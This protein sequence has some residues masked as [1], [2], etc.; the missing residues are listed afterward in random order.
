MTDLFRA[1]LG[2]SI[3][4][5]PIIGVLLLNTVVN[6]KRKERTNQ[7]L[8]PIITLVYVYLIY[9][10]THTIGGFINTISKQLFN[11]EIKGLFIFTAVNVASVVAYYIWKRA[12]L[13]FFK[14]IFSKNSPIH[15]YIA[16][17]FYEYNPE[18]STWYLK[19][20][21]IQ[22]RSFLK[23]SYIAVFIVSMIAAMAICYARQNEKVA[24]LFYPVIP[25]LIFGDIYAFFNGIS[26]DEDDIIVVAEKSKTSHR[27][28]YSLL[29]PVLG[30]LFKDK[31]IAEGTTINNEE[32]S[33]DANDVSIQRILNDDEVKIEAYGA[34]M[35]N[36]LKHGILLKQDYLYAGLELLKGK[37]LLFNN[38]FYYD[39][40]PYVFFVMN[41]ILLK[42]KK[43]LIILGRHGIED[44]I[45]EWCKKGISEVTG[46]PYIWNIDILTENKTN[47]DIGILTR[48]EVCN[49]T[50][51][52]KNEDFLSDAEFVFIVEPS[53]LITTAQ[54]GLNSLVR[55]SKDNSKVIFCSTDK[56]CDGLIDSLSHILQTSISE[57]AATNHHIGTSSYMCWSADDEKLQHRMIS[58]IS[59]YL[60]IGTELSFVALK[61][62]VRRTSWYGGERFPV[63]DMHWIAKQYY[64][65][66]LKYADLPITQEYM[67][68]C[69][70]TSSNL[71]NAKVQ[72]INYMT[73]EDEANNLFEARRLFASRALEQGFVNII[74]TNYVL[75]EYMAQNDKIFDADSK[76]I[77]YIVADYDRT[78]RNVLMR[79]LLYMSGKGISE[80]DLKRELKL[81]GIRS[82]NVFESFWDLLCECF[83][84]SVHVSYDGEKE[85]TIGSKK[86]VFTSS[87]FLKK[88]KFSKDNDKLNIVYYLCD[89][90]FNNAILGDLQNVSIIAEDENGTNN[91]LGTEVKGQVFQ[92]YLPGQ[93][94][95]FSGKYYEMIK[96]TNDAQLIVRRAAEHIRG[97]EEY[98][99]IRNYSLSNISYSKEMG[100]VTR[101]LGIK[102]QIGYADITVTTRSYWKMKVYND[103]KTGE[104][105][106]VDNIP[107]REYIK[108]RFLKLDFADV[109]HFES[110]IVKMLTILLNE[111]FRTIF[112]DN[113][114]YI[115][116]VSQAFSEIPDLYTIDAENEMLGSAI[117]FI[118]DSQLDIGLLT[119]LRRNIDRIF[120]IIC[121]FLD[122]Y[123]EFYEL[124]NANLESED[125]D[126]IDI[127]DEG[128]E[129]NEEDTNNDK[130]AG[131]EKEQ[132]NESTEE[133]DKEAEQKKAEIQYQKS[134]YLKFGDE[135]YSQELHVKKTLDFLEEL[136][137]SNSELKQ[138]RKGSNISENY[139][140]LV[141]SGH[142]C[143]FCGRAISGVDFE[144]MNDGR[145]R[146]MVCA[147]NAITEENEFIRIFVEVRENLRLFY[148]INL[149]GN[150]E[151]KMVNASTISK[152]S[153]KRFIPSE[154]AT[155]R[156]VGLACLERDGRFV[157]LVENG[158]P[159]LQIVLALAHE[160]T[161]IWQYQNW[162]FKQLKQKYQ[163][164]QIEV[165]EGMAVWAEVQYAYLIN[166]P[167]VAKRRYNSIIG[168]DDDYGRGLKRYI[169]VY[170]ISE[171]TVLVGKTPFVD[172]CLDI[173]E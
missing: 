91:Y 17:K 162:D 74:S 42:H 19:E 170:P 125:I 36:K 96:V 50:L 45:K 57:V 82:E 108:K 30:N 9:F 109:S 12:L 24:G 110:E 83:A 127:K 3:Y 117:Y 124:D 154:K 37:S 143:D 159:R 60:G 129:I 89:E 160:L 90:R 35:R 43:V 13:S 121:D 85:M 97:R 155:V 144:V 114:S 79:I 98:R 132:L 76:A 21:C 69:M 169:D 106:I 115:I 150:I 87:V 5:L 136:K 26:K 4:V 44:D 81:M 145:E 71:W 172:N 14:K 38:P 67:E 126:K 142:Q 15:D 66:L 18:D 68:Q 1:I 33:A 63:T 146:C 137:Y 32:D 101:R 120:A 156:A 52:E 84:S 128:E 86:I 39:L 134:N 100:D 29:R 116:A 72:N 147:R 166:E 31:L 2:Q 140:E 95:V 99:Q 111:V 80:S 171:N 107:K 64:Y 133:I 118:E 11:Y 163:N 49:Q 92:K 47:A 22:A 53:K 8:M 41:H 54:I 149:K 113:Q 152:K 103:F 131:I 93:Y 10:I 59:R 28:N 94:F 104:E 167:I 78:R 153:G 27:A 165:L 102:S 61:N 105:V 7:F 25:I 130:E 77:P 139:D 51:Y 55:F 122:W 148:G 65:V 141:Q 48:S 46:N 16:G 151:V 158:A 168:K 73:I 20:K 119:A 138:A 58:G 135:K 34:F 56:N 23:M 75:R 6:L 62:Q 70:H 157:V 161:H 112:S 40:I 123:N 173:I 164:A 88:R